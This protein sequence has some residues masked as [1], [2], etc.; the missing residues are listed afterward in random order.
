MIYPTAYP[1]FFYFF[2]LLVLGEEM[3]PEATSFISLET[4]APLA[5]CDG[6]G[7]CEKNDGGVLFGETM[8][9][10]LSP[11]AIW[12]DFQA[13]FL[14]TA[15]PTN[16]SD[17]AEA[18]QLQIGDIVVLD[19]D[20]KPRL[21]SAIL[22]TTTYRWFDV[23]Y[24]REII[25]NMGPSD[26]RDLGYLIVEPPVQSPDSFFE[27]LVQDPLLAGIPTDLR[28]QVDPAMVIPSP[29]SGCRP[30]R[31]YQ[32]IASADVFYFGPDPTNTACLSA[33]TSSPPVPTTPPISI[34]W[35]GA[36]AP[37][38]ASFNSD[39]LSTLEYKTDAPPE[40][41]V[42]NYADLPCPPP[43]IAQH[44]KPEF[45]YSPLLKQLFRTYVYLN[46]SSPSMVCEQAAVRDPPLRAVRVDQITGPKDGGDTIA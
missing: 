6:F 32:F 35:V 21:R 18:S 37:F 38:T 8:E 11:P 12:V 7:L 19:E 5:R 40:T 24:Y 10:H 17:M 9:K 16:P 46:A 33:I 2:A 29:T 44:Y 39:T 43:D 4:G 14:R 20:F 22:Q 34:R 1:F 25:E 31:C 26:S 36:N 28:S 15:D 27:S 3:F 41:K 23:F 13:K 45:P 30:D 42:M